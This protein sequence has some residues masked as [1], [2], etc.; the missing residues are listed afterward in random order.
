MGGRGLVKTG[1]W[2]CA[3]CVPCEEP[4]SCGYKDAKYIKLVLLYRN[5]FSFL[6]KIQYTAVKDLLKELSS[7][8]ICH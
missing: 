3:M 5:T 2:N 7:I 4:A 8:K 1:L 6:Y